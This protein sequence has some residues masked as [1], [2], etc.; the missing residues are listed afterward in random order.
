MTREHGETITNSIL[1]RLI[2]LEP[3]SEVENPPSRAQ[4]VRQLKSA[5]R[6][7]LEWLLNTRRT[8]E[9][10]EDRLELET[11]KQSLYVYGI[12]DLS[13][14]TMANSADRNLLK[15]VV[16]DAIK[17]FENRLSQIRVDFVDPS[18]TSSSGVRLRIDAMLRMDPVPEPISFDTVIDL[19]G[20]DCHLAG[21]D[22]AR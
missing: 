6:R 4:S 18:S 19:K 11:V 14:L 13:S 15:R 7:D 10:P 3:G 1:D 5:V 16:T 20:S 2:D 9:I 22:D 17:I 12:P 8:P 21:A